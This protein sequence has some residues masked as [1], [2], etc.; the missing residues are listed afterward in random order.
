MLSCFVLLSAVLTT[1]VSR[2][3][4][5]QIGIAEFLK[6]SSFYYITR[7]GFAVGTSEINVTLRYTPSI[8]AGWRG[9]HFI[10]KNTIS[11]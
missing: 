5:H 2:L 11:S 6:Q 4:Q 7:M 8:Y 1:A 3:E 9:G 10:M